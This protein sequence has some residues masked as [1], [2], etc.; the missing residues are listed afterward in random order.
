MHI[1]VVG[2]PKPLGG[3]NTELLHALRLWRRGGLE[4]TLI[5]TWTTPPDWKPLVDELGL[6]TVETTPERLA[7]V[8]GLAGSV[9][10]SY[11]KNEFLA[12]AHHFRGLGCRIVWVNCMCWMFPAERYHLS[13]HGP[14]DR[15]VFHSRY[16]QDHYVPQ[17]R[18]HGYQDSQGRVIRGAFDRTLFPLSPLD[19]QP[20]D[21]FVVGRLSRL[22]RDKYP[23]DL[24]SQYA[25]I[26]YPTSARVLGWGEEAKRKCGPPPP[27]ATAL[28]ELAETAQQFLGA[29]HAL[30]PGVGCCA[31]NWPRVGLEAMAAGVPVV[32]ERRG[33]WPEMLDGGGLLVDSADE[34]AYQVA[35]L[36]YEQRYRRQMIEQGRERL[37]ILSD[38]EAFWRD[39]QALLSDIA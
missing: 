2:Y 10:V 24:W 12:D 18:R 33:G 37:E 11:C 25:R 27:W 5:P 17:L 15:Y 3:G 23:A 7:E 19:H 28:P 26:P 1:F 21:R 35:R 9:V 20:G 36:A 29:C 14:F 39:W 16:Q 31:E 6:R 34:Q 30:V 8:P 4:I 22:D 13:K 38:P 32:A